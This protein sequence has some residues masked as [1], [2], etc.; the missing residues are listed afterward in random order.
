MRLR[1][2]IAALSGVDTT[3]VKA[4]MVFP[5]ASVDASFGTTGHVHCLRLARLHDYICS[6]KY[7]KKLSKERVEVFV[8]AMH[9]VAGMDTEFSTISTAAVNGLKSGPLRPLVVQ[10]SRETEF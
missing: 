1:D 7:S 9:G 10:I 3:H 6:E 5:K 8:R 4:V 2:Q